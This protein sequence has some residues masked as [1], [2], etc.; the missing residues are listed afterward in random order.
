MVMVLVC[1]RTAGKHPAIHTLVRMNRNLFVTNNYADKLSFDNSAAW[2]G[3]PENHAARC[4]AVL[5]WRLSGQPIELAPAGVGHRN[6]PLAANKLRHRRRY[7][8][9]GAGGQAGSRLERI[10]S[11]RRG[12]RQHR[13]ATRSRDTYT[14]I[15]REHLIRSKKIG[16]LHVIGR[17]YPV[18][19]AEF[20]NIHVHVWI[21]VKRLADVVEH[22]A[23]RT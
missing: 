20:I 2:F 15:G 13:V 16:G 6:L 21:I 22:A 19:N 10:R 14:G 17:K 23:H 1:A 12:P 7:S 9:P 4:L 8:R 3:D 18:V 11:R 5:V